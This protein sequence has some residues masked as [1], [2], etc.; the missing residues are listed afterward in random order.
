MAE[1]VRE[2][3]SGQEGIREAPPTPT[4]PAPRGLHAATGALSLRGV[5][6]AM[7]RGYRGVVWLGRG[8]GDQAA[9][10]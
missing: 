4:A 1:H 5:P 8:R 2:P 7:P 6:V 3:V 10:G 9:K